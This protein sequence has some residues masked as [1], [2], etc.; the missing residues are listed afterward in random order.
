MKRY[1]NSCLA[2]IVLLSVSC[3]KTDNPRIP[4]LARVPVPYIKADATKSQSISVLNPAAFTQTFTFTPYFTSDVPPK[5][6]D[7]VVIKNGVNSSVK[8]IQAGLT[9]F[10]ASVDVTGTQLVTLFGTIKLGDTYTFGLDITAQDGTV[11]HA[12]P[13]LGVGYGSGVLNEY[14]GATNVTPLAAGGGVVYQIAFGALC[15]YDPA[16]YQ[17]N[18]VVVKDDWQDT[19]PGDIIVFTPIDATHF[20]FIY[21]TAVNPKPIIVTVNPANNTPSIALQTI[22]SAWTY[23]ATPPPPTAKTTAS[24]KNNLAPCDKTISLNMTWTEGPGSFGD[25]VFSLRKQ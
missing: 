19:K 14:N 9:T 5:Q 13:Q 25:L 15:A 8:T 21:P 7:L 24:A 17:G 1:I 11:F 2:L 22:G 20:S 16:I 10:P 4:T 6:M 23:D 3:R 18:F 12:F